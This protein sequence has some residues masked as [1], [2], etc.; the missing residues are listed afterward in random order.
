M[1]GLTASSLRLNLYSYSHLA[2]QTF[3][4]VT[5]QISRVLMSAYYVQG[6]EAL[7]NSQRKSLI[8]YGC[9][10]SKRVEILGF[11]GSSFALIT[12]F[13]SSFLALSTSRRLVLCTPSCP[14]KGYSYISPPASLLGLTH[15]TRFG[16]MVP[17]FGCL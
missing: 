12:Q 7:S 6:A 5:K 14:G 8:K 15:F 4:K 9:V 1:K 10:S 11:G 3:T 16:L 17:Y 13:S 2:Q